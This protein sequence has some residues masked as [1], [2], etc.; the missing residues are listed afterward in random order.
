MAMEV[1]KL[2]VTV[3]DPSK[4]PNFSHL[5]ED[6]QKSAWE[7]WLRSEI[8]N[9][10][11]SV[12]SSGSTTPNADALLSAIAASVIQ[13]VPSGMEVDPLQ[14][15][16]SKRMRTPTSTPLVRSVDSS[17]VFKKPCLGGTT[18]SSGTLIGS[19]TLQQSPL[20]SASLVDQTPPNL[21][22]SP[23]IVPVKVD[24]PLSKMEENSATSLVSRLEK[25]HA[26][27]QGSLTDMQQLVY[28][29]RSGLC[30]QVSALNDRANKMNTDVSTLKA[31]IKT[32]NPV[33]KKLQKDVQDKNKGL[34]TRVTTL[35]AAVLKKSTDG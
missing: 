34:L 12:A 28:D 21:S 8:S 32:V 23:K 24:A 27:F 2:K 33:V 17:P 25:P 19:K 30:A 3:E 1:D 7:T 20:V 11:I 26:T 6:E 16:I 9:G 35:E 31:E 13:E 22:L 15:A 18:G 5:S 10:S 14:P 29:T 4:I